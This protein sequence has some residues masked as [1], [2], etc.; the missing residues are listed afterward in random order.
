MRSAAASGARVAIENPLRWPGASLGAVDT[1]LVVVPYRP[2]PL[3][4]KIIGGSDSILAK[5]L[6]SE[7]GLT[8]PSLR[9]SFGLRTRDNEWFRSGIVSDAQ[10][11]MTATKRTRLYLAQNPSTGTPPNAF[12]DS[13]RRQLFR[14]FT[15]SVLG[16]CCL[17]T[18]IKMLHP[19][20]G[21]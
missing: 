1:E 17:R 7:V 4:P 19:R 9:S 14:I 3:C 16:A 18:A 11:K 10:A 21:S 2:Q 13:A 5:G 6:E 12:R 15:G 8:S 20:S